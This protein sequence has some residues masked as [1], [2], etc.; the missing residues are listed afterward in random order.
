MTMAS[1]RRRW[2]VLVAV[3]LLVIAAGYR[4]FLTS[5][6]PAGQPPL[7]TLDGASMESLRADFNRS[8]AETRI[9]V[10]LSPT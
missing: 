8:A 4:Y 2:I 10:L 7:A 9:I 3:A 6:V 1:T 5:Q